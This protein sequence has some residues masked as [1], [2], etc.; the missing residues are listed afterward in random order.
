MDFKSNGSNIDKNKEGLKKYIK[1]A[2]KLKDKVS[3][4]SMSFQ[5]FRKYFHTHLMYL[6]TF[7]FYFIKS[8]I[9]FAFL[10]KSTKLELLT[11][12]FFIFFCISIYSQTKYYLIEK[13]NSQRNDITTNYCKY[14]QYLFVSFVTM[15]FRNTVEKKIVYKII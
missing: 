11:I 5:L 3:Y 13:E 8:F 4:E 10:A 1:K 15:H 14:R 12:Q 6:H 2:T 7:I 9:R